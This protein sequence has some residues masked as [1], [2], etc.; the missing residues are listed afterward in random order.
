MLYDETLSHWL[1][2]D[3]GRGIAGTIAGIAGVARAHGQ[4]ERAA[5]LLGAAWGLGDTLG[6][7]FLAHHLYAERVLALVR[8]RLDAATFTAAWEAGRAL[9]LGEA[10]DEARAALS[11]PDAMTRAVDGL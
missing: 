3:D 7:R 9:T 6:V 11:L 10:I 5:R 1:A 2:C 4:L 8:S